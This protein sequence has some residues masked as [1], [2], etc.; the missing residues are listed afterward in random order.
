MIGVDTFRQRHKSGGTVITLTVSRVVIGVTVRS[1]D[2]QKNDRQG[3]DRQGGG[4][5][6]VLD[7]TKGTE[8][9]NPT[10]YQL[11]INH[12]K[13]KFYSLMSQRHPGSGRSAAWYLL[14]VVAKAGPLQRDC[15]KNSWCCSTSGHAVRSQSIRPFLVFAPYSGSGCQYLNGTTLDSQGNDSLAS[16]GEAIIYIAQKDAEKLGNYSEYDQQNESPL[17]GEKLKEAQKV[18]R[19]RRRHRRAIR[20][21]QPGEIVCF[22]EGYKYH[23]FKRCLLSI[24][25]K[26]V[27]DLILHGRAW[28]SI[29]RPVK[30]ESMRNK[31]D[32]FFKIFG[33]SSEREALGRP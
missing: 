26:T 10:I 8:A 2:R 20:S 7:A 15:K 28:E 14:Q 3:S 9:G 24:R 17:A 30:T 29:T 1:D 19:V 18:R 16:G 25:Y 21:Y 4:G 31:D 23:L 11:G 27:K 13:Y 6:L 32:P 22:L 33:E 12:L 5:I